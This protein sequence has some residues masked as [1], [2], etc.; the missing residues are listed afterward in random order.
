VKLRHAAALLPLYATGASAVAGVGLTLFLLLSYLLED[1]FNGGS[2]FFCAAA[3]A[4]VWALLP[5]AGLNRTSGA[6]P[7]RLTFA[8][9]SIMFMIMFSFAIGALWIT[10]LLLEV[11]AAVPQW[12]VGPFSGGTSEMHRFVAAIR[13]PEAT[14]RVDRWLWL[15]AGVF[16]L[17]MIL[18]YTSARLSNKSRPSENTR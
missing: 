13:T 18:V 11:V 14:Q 12:L 2:P 1:R 6:D 4:A 9:F 5:F 3:T 15:S 17:S 10:G 8:S 7:E 16:C